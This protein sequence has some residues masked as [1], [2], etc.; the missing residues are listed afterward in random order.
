MFAA[1]PYTPY[2]IQQQLMTNMYEAL[3]S[4]QFGL[5]ESP[6]G[7]GKTLSVICST[8]KWLENERL[9][10][11]AASLEAG[12]EETSLPDWMRPSQSAPGLTDAPQTAAAKHARARKQAVPNQVLLDEEGH[13]LSEFLIGDNSA[14]GKGPSATS[15][16]GA[17]KRRAPEVDYA[18]TSSE[19]EADTPA[20]TAA[21]YEAHGVAEKHKQPQMIFCSRTHSQLSQFVRELHRTRYADSTT[22][23]AV[24]SRKA[25]CVND[26]VR[27]LE[28]LNHINE[29]CLDLQRNKGSSS[30][31]KAASLGPETFATAVEQ[32]GMDH[33]GQ[34]YS[35]S[36]QKTSQQR[37]SKARQKR[38]NKASGCFF[39]A[40]K[41]DAASWESFKELVL[42]API[43]VEELANMGRKQKICPYYG[44]RR[45]VPSADVILAPYSAVLMPDARES[46][47]IQ[48]EG[49]VVVFDEAH[50]LLDAINGAHS[51]AVSAWQLMSVQRSLTAYYERFRIVLNPSNAQHVKTMLQI[52]ATLHSC[53]VSPGSQG[54]STTASTCGSVLSVN[55]LLFTANLDHINM[56]ELARWVKDNKMAYKV[57]CVLDTAPQMLRPAR[58]ADEVPIALVTAN[59]PVDWV[60]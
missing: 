52:A 38:S 44:C 59:Q 48:L 7:T 4:N 22:L 20:A 15:A 26:E 18:S 14:A 54:S 27:R 39:L 60:E 36:L 23:V 43:D 50:N 40:A 57:R 16:S 51:T 9:S 41:K 34:G 29:R 49:S 13:D 6:T 46:L 2:G 45:A 12:G 21:A 28:E 42:A 35:N 56:F 11:A 1:F 19:D 8:L 30:S 5:F 24:G 3:Q 33:G 10:Q 17:A 58:A 25:L 37:G 31:R 53:L 55:D 32:E 47:G